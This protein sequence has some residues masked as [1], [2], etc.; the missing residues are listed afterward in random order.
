MSYHDI[1]FIKSDIKVHEKLTKFFRGYFFEAPRIER[2]IRH[3]NTHGE[4]CVSRGSD[5]TSVKRDGASVPPPHPK[6]MYVR[7]HG[8]TDSKAILH[9]DQLR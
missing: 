9:S 3:G 5:T 6:K 2:Q 4:K 1:K 8:M 7:S